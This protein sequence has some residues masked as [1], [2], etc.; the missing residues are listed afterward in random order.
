M[1]DNNVLIVL[2]AWRDEFARSHRYDVKAMAAVL[3]D[4]DKLAG[5]RIMQGEQRR[6]E[7]V[8]PVVGST[9]SHRPAVL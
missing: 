5:A 8:L 4:L 2:G 7:A 3:R 6:P 9:P 1:N